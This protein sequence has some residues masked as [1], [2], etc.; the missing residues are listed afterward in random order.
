MKFL[1][2]SILIFN[3][4]FLLSCE[5][6][7]DE[8][9]LSR[10]PE[11]KEKVVIT[12]FI[13]PQ[14]EVIQIRLNKSVPLYGEISGKYIKIFDPI[15]S[16]SVLYYESDKYIK[17]A[18]VL[19][20][21]GKEST[22]LQYSEEFRSYAIAKSKFKIEAGQTLNLT[23]NWNKETLTSSTYIPTDV[24]PIEN[25]SIDYFSD[26]NT[27]FF[28]SDTTQGY[29]VNFN[30]KDIAGKENYYKIW[31]ELEY[32]VKLPIF[33]KDKNVTFKDRNVYGYLFWPDSEITGSERYQADKGLDGNIIKSINGEINERRVRVCPGE[34]SFEGKG[35]LTAKVVPNSRQN[36]KLQLWNTSKEL[37]EYHISLRKF[38]AS[39]NNPFS[40]PTPVFTNI[41]NGLGIFAGYNGY[42]VSKRVQ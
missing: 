32:L 14:D 20:S 42:E 22:N 34:N 39:S 7:V 16:D 33:D 10:F 21:N 37:Y 15:T 27:G 12:A 35:C 13:S 40:E 5:T 18:Q 11:L 30:Y 28:G 6:I 17:D 1:K 2:I 24:V 3:L 36:I 31:G 26:I 19:L 23:V 29:K 9:N 4:I 8:V 38:N 25:L 41:K